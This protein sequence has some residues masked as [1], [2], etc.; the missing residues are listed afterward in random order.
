MD[1]YTPTEEETAAFQGFVETPL[2]GADCDDAHYVSIFGSAI[3]QAHRLVRGRAGEIPYDDAEALAEGLVL[4]AALGEMFGIT[5]SLSPNLR[6]RCRPALRFM[7]RLQANESC[8]FGRPNDFIFIN[9][10]N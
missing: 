7:D 10:R 8:R 6:E 9:H 3:T 1:Q 2:T 5:A 4:G